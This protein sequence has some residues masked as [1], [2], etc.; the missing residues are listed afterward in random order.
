MSM[1]E[2]K[3]KYYALLDNA[4]KEM[5]LDLSANRPVCEKLMLLIHELYESAKVSEY[6]KKGQYS[7]AYHNPITGDFEF[8]V[9]RTLSHY[10]DLNKLNWTISL[11]RQSNGCTPDVRVEIANETVF[12]IEIKVKAGWIQ[13]LFS[14][15]AYQNE[16]KKFKNGNAANPQE[17][18]AGF[19]AQF[20]KYSDSFNSKRSIDVYCLLPTMTHVHRIRTTEIYTLDD[21]REFFAANSGLAKE[22][23]IMLSSNLTLNLSGEITRVELKATRELDKMIVRMKRKSEI[24]LG[25][26]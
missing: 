2:I 6:N 13:T 26:Q 14:P 1:I 22:N 25:R 7:S 4:A 10:S 12:I 11:R 24:M 8:I 3:K 5:A 9:S 17:I 16:M 20:A 21:Y 23:L 19:R 15:R 18:I